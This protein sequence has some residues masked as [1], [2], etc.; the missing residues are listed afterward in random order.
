MFSQLGIIVSFEDINF[1]KKLAHSLIRSTE[2]L[3]AVTV[4]RD[5]TGL[6]AVTSMILQLP[7]NKL[8]WM[9]TLFSKKNPKLYKQVLFCDNYA[10]KVIATHLQVLCTW[11]LVCF[12]LWK[13]LCFCNTNIF[14]K[15]WSLLNCCCGVL[16]VC[17]TVKDMRAFALVWLCWFTAR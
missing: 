8:R 10:N 14:A 6:A 11:L 4:W 17:T 2:C 12:W 5:F 1:L 13:V 16:Y 15:E 7:V 9:R 3:L